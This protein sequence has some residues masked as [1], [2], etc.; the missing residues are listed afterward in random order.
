[1]KKPSTKSMLLCALFAAM[2]AILSQL[3][4]PLPFTPVPVNLATLSV[5]L[6]GAVLGAKRGLVSQT[7]YVL[8]GAIGLPVFSKMTGGLSVL[9][10]PTGGYLIG[11]ILAAGLTGLMVDKCPQKLYIPPISM[12]C[13][14]AICYAF[15]TAWYV[16]LTKSAIPQAL[17]MCVVP[18]LPGDALKIIAAS[19][20][21]P[22]LRQYAQ[23]PAGQ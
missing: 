21:T 20:L 19:F 11:Y 1:M 15:G 22:K 23:K 3:A 2:T 4:L 12:V 7:V 5:L 10:G 16:I 14:L 8:L 17:L 6:C 18:F 9:A 13:G